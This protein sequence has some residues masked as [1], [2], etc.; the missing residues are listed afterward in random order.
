M[1]PIVYVLEEWKGTNSLFFFFFSRK[2]S[3]KFCESLSNIYRQQVRVL[4]LNIKKFCYF[5][6]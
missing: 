4:N 3:A 5:I 6:C 2:F 1:T